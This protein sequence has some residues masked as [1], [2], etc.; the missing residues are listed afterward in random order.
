MMG[1]EGM[2]YGRRKDTTYL[3][4]RGHP[5]PTMPPRHCVRLVVVEITCKNFA[6]SRVTKRDPPKVVPAPPAELVNQ[7]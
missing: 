6:K 5:T 1:S 7:K 4:Q 2:P 3:V